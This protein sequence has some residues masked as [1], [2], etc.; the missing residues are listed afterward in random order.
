MS[1][2]N[3]V[4]GGLVLGVVFVI[5]IIKGLVDNRRAKKG[6]KALDKDVWVVVVLLCGVFMALVVHGIEQFVNT[7]IFSFIRDAFLYAAAAS[8]VYKT[9]SITKK[10]I[11]QPSGL[12]NG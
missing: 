6:R 7:N 5:Q 10:K 9:Y 3:Y 11:S 2:M 4:Q 8:F 1:I 12:V